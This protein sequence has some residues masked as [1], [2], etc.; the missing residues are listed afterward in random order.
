MEPERERRARAP[1][2]GRRRAPA[3]GF[4]APPLRAHSAPPS[5]YT[6]SFNC[7]CTTSLHRPSRDAGG[8]G[9]PAAA[10]VHSRP[11][12]RPPPLRL[13]IAGG[14]QWLPRPAPGRAAPL[15]RRYK[16]GPPRAARPA[17][18][19]RGAT[20]GRAE[21]VRRRR[22][23]ARAAGVRPRGVLAAL[24]VLRGG[25]GRGDG[26]AHHQQQPLGSRGRGRARG[27][28]RAAGA[29]GAASCADRGSRGTPVRRRSRA[30][31]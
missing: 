20:R 11:G 3:V 21:D 8:P 17:E 28:E 22:A 10:A 24:G 7:T 14:G 4:P 19:R 15:R 26:P 18:R 6:R 29:L 27:R 31:R 1:R 16:S 30:R 23:R 12:S 25:R 5:V 2:A 9:E 13:G